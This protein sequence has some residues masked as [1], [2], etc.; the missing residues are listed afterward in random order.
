MPCERNCTKYVVR[1]W[2]GVQIVSLQVQMLTLNDPQ[3][4]TNE[5]QN[6]DDI[7]RGSTLTPNCSGDSAIS[8]T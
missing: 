1:I 8:T 4:L 7:N 3:M 5:S 2:S 6:N